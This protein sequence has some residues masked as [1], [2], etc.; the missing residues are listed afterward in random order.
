MMDLFV[1]PL[2]LYVHY[3]SADYVFVVE[4]ECF[5]LVVVVIVNVI[6][7]GV[8][9]VRRDKK[10]SYSYTHQREWTPHNYKLCLKQ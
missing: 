4:S 1:V 9:V 3:C 5:H 10:M 7:S 6:V 8:S 2:A